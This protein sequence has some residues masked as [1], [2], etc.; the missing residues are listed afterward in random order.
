MADAYRPP[1]KFQ[2]AVEQL[3]NFTKLHDRVITF[4]IVVCVAIIA[5]MVMTAHLMAHPTLTFD[6]KWTMTTGKLETNFTKYNPRLSKRALAALEANCAGHSATFGPQ[7][8]VDGKPWNVA[9][10][11]MCD[12]ALHLTDPEA[13]VVGDTRV[14]CQ[15]EHL[16]VYKIKRRRHPIT[17]ATNDGFTHTITDAQNSCVVWNAIELIKGI[18]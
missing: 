12:L 9:H 6:D 16:G 11:Y 4:V 14:T 7:V 8:R 2:L 5:S 10:V 3:E 17:V 15:D 18:W 13:I 1:S